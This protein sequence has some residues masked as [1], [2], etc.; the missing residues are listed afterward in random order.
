MTQ[1]D[2]LN[3]IRHELDK[4][5]KQA[6][7]Y[8]DRVVV[9][10]H[11][12]ESPSSEEIGDKIAQ[13]LGQMAFAIRGAPLLGEADQRDLG[14]NAKKMRAALRLRQYEYWDPHILHDEGTVLGVRPAGQ[15]EV[16]EVNTHEARDLFKNAYANVLHILGLITPGGSDFALIN[17]ASQ[18]QDVTKSRPDTAFIMM[19][20]DREHHELEDVRNAIREVFASFEIKAVRAD[21]IQ[22]DDIITARVLKEIETSEFL[23][24]DLTGVRPNVYYE[25]GYAHALRKRVILFRKKGTS[26]HFD[27]AN[28]NCREY[29]NLSDLKEQLKKHLEHLTSKTPTPR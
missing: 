2:D 19:W 4:I 26:L 29:V 1:E 25:V 3:T 7:D 18:T 22:H 11:I 20:M 8:F 23:I 10:R 28:Y 5:Y 17:Q 13:I 9:E 12:A 24:A 16:A 6:L 14:I 27:L 21:D 15:S